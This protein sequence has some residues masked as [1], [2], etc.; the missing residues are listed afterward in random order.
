MK[1]ISIILKLIFFLFINYTLFSVEDSKKGIRL[2]DENYKFK[3]YA[4]LIGINQYTDHK[5]SKLDKAVNDAKN[6]SQILEDKKYANFDKVFQLTDSDDFKSE[7]YPLKSNIE[8]RINST[9]EQLEPED[10][11]IIFFSGHGITDEKGNGYLIAFDTK[12]SN[13][14]ETSVSVNRIVQKI[15]NKG[16]KKSLLILDAC[17]SVFKKGKSVG[18]DEGLKNQIFKNAEISATFYSTKDGHYSYEDSGSDNGVFTRFI[19]EGIRS[20]ADSN[21]DNLITFNELSKFVQEGVSSWSHNKAY[22]QI[23]YIKYNDETFGDLIISTY[24]NPKKLIDVSKYN[25]SEMSACLWA[26][27]KNGYAYE[28]I[29]LQGGIFTYF[30]I[31]GLEKDADYDSDGLVTLLEI[32]NYINSHVAGYLD[33]NKEK[34]V[35]QYPILS[36]NADIF[37]DFYITKTNKGS[38]IIYNKDN[39][40]KGINLSDSVLESATIEDRIALII[41][42]NEYE[43]KNIATLK[44]AVS[45]ALKINYLLGENGNFVRIFLM[46]DKDATTKNI[47]NKI[48]EINKLGAQSVLI[49]YSGHGFSSKDDDYIL[50]Y[51]ANINFIEKSSLSLKDMTNALKAKNKIFILDTDRDKIRNNSK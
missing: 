38:E 2:I 16:I 39:K 30:L 45:D 4:I 24:P 50:T 27:K 9:I 23:P 26:T 47:M 20:G 31:R 14:Y 32:N 8:E 6:F 5:I 13:P 44:F 15:K 7:N 36:I 29:D 46:K 28:T 49:Y 40:K 3:K 22:D 43:E 25:N 11:L 19:I 42:I 51:D 10:L 18:N 21:K 48:E 33:E 41:G 35:R 12:T 1:F 17:R 34:K 37:N